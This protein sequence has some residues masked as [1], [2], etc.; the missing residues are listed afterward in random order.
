MKLRKNHRKIKRI[1]LAAEKN[2]IIQF[3][4]NNKKKN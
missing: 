2:L 1:K 4:F 3:F